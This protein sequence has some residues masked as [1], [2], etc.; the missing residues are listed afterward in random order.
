MFYIR[1]LSCNLVNGQDELC[2]IRIFLLKVL[3]MLQSLAILSFLFFIATLVA[4]PMLIN[5]LDSCYFLHLKNSPPAGP[6]F[7]ETWKNAGKDF[8]LI[9]LRNVAGF[10]ILFIGLAMLVLPGQG[11]LTILIGLCIMDFPGK[12]KMI[13]LLVEKRYVQDTLNWI[14]RKGGCAVFVFE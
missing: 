10:F 1:K 11:I 7:S 9:L 4:V 14:R 6:L 2:F 3:H 13:L 8:F 12:K 5:R